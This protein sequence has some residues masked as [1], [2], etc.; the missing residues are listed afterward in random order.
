MAQG[1]GVRLLV[2]SREVDHRHPVLGGDEVPVDPGKHLDHVVVV[3]E[4]GVFPL[5]VPGRKFG[6][7]FHLNPIQDRGVQLLAPAEAR[8]D[9]DP[10]HHAGLILLGFI[11]EP[12]SGGLPVVSE[13]VSI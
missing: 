9:R 8:A 12:N 13:D 7:G 3:T 1:Y 10:N 4:F 2:N 5:D 6:D 11:P